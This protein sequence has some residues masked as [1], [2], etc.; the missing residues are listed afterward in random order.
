LQVLELLEVL[1]DDSSTMGA[2]AISAAQIKENVVT[3]Q[4]FVISTVL[5]QAAGSYRKDSG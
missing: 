2:N 5:A 3:K 1:G 4:A